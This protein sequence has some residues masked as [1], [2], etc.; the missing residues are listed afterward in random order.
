MPWLCFAVGTLSEAGCPDD[1]EAVVLWCSDPEWA[2]SSLNNTAADRAEE[3]LTQ[4]FGSS[5]DHDYNDRLLQLA[6]GL[7]RIDMRRFTVI[8]TG[9]RASGL[10]Q[11]TDS[12]TIPKGVQNMV[13]GF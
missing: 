11:K 2:G 12:M 13:P 4:W 7:D 3:K 10:R 6:L 9:I 5:K 8:G 1:P